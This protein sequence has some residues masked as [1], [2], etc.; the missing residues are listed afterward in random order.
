[1][2]KENAFSFKIKGDFFQNKCKNDIFFTIKGN[3]FQEKRILFFQDECKKCQK[4][5]FFQD[6]R[7]LQ[8]EFKQGTFF[9]DKK[10]FFKILRGLFQ[11]E[12][13]Q[14]IFFSR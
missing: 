6:K 8:D 13:K 9:Q 2:N 10:G 5:V 3:F 7:G 4:G 1:M 11:D 14:G 12:C